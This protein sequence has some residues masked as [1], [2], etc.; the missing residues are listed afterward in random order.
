MSTKTRRPAFTLI[1]LLV[2]IAIIGILMAM[3][4]P[5]VQ[6]VREAAR[7][8]NCLNNIRQ[9]GIAM[10]NYESTL[11][12]YP[13]GWIERNPNCSGAV[14]PDCASYR[15]GWATLILPF[16]EGDNLYK[17]YDIREG[18]W[19]DPSTA[20]IERDSISVVDIYICPS[21]PIEGANP[22]VEN[23]V[24]AKLNY[25]GSIGQDYMDNFLNQSNGGSGIFYMNSR[26]KN[27]D[28]RDGT[29]HVITHGER[30][31]LNPDDNQ[32]HN[33]G[34]RI[35]LIEDG[36][37]P[38]E[39]N[40]IAFPGLELAGQVAQGP[41]DP[42]VYPGAPIDYTNFG[43]KGSGGGGGVDRIYAYTVGYSSPHPG[44][45]SFLFADGSTLFINDIISV[46]IFGLLLNKADGETV[47][48]GAFR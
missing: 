15:Y 47:D 42:N 13:E 40:G 1:E 43:V 16:I 10:H 20:G 14:V 17:N 3:L 7:R 9:I 35:G 8:T 33:Q 4:L 38:N 31:G 2:V 29:S 21:D 19:D 41:Y 28:I 44:G 34:I 5:A 37:A 27:R 22:V 30:G 46:D 48:T 18:F 32:Y 25:M 11:N 36:A 24:H 39:L 23:G 45:A 6:M 12:R 26:T